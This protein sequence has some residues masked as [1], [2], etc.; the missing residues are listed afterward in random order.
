MFFFGFMWFQFKLDTRCQRLERVR[1]SDS[2]RRKRCSIR[3]PWGRWKDAEQHD[4]ISFLFS[5][6]ST[7]WREMME[8]TCAGQDQI[9]TENPWKNIKVSK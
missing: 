8:R 4:G 7:F 5:G 3:I 6:F 1:N 9:I 2:S